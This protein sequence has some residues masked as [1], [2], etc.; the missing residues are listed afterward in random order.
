[1]RILSLRRLAPGFGDNPA[2]LPHLGERGVVFAGDALDD[3]P[4]PLRRPLAVM[5]PPGKAV[6][7]ATARHKGIPVTPAPVKANDIETCIE[8]VAYALNDNPRDINR[9]VISP[10]CRTLIVRH[11][12]SLSPC[13]GRGRG[14]EAEKG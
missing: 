10:L 4:I 1:V 14:A 3:A 5:P 12:R 6:S 9:L 11:G 8:A 2:Q 13:Q 7:A